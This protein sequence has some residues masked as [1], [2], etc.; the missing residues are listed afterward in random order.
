MSTQYG[1][2]ISLILLEHF[3]EVVEK[4]ALFLYKS[5]SCPLAL[6]AKST[7]L[8]VSKVGRLKK[9]LNNLFF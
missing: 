2:L 9:V 8:P 6:I 3:G 5:G 7:E 4:V 1:K